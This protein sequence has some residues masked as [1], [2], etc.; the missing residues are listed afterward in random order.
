MVPVVG[1]DG[2]TV[3]EYCRG[4]VVVLQVTDDMEL[5]G[6]GVVLGV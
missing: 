3:K 6:G 4:D 1:S 2:F 5:T